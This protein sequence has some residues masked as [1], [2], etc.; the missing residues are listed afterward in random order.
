LIV[1][2][3][4]NQNNQLEGKVKNLSIASPTSSTTTKSKGTAITSPATSSTTKE[5]NNLLP[6]WLSEE[7]INTTSTTTVKK[8]HSGTKAAATPPPPTST[9]KIPLS[10]SSHPLSSPST[11]S[12]EAITPPSPVIASNI[13]KS[14][15]S[16]HAVPPPPPAAVDFKPLTLTVS[17]PNANKKKKA[18]LAVST[19]KPLDTNDMLKMITRLSTLSNNSIKVIQIL[20]NTTKLFNAK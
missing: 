19:L 16:N 18:T 17:T 10:P 8:P 6:S 4:N 1:A 11:K 9:H 5:T 13:K 14:N 7:N 20:E 2:H 3:I 12:A 15:D